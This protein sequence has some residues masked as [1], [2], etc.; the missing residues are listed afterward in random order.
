MHVQPLGAVQLGNGGGSHEN[1]G[2]W[3]PWVKGIGAGQ[4]RLWH[5]P[6]G[7]KGVDGAEASHRTGVEQSTA[8][9]ALSRERPGSLKF[10]EFFRGGL[11]EASAVGRVSTRQALPQW[12][13]IRTREPEDP[14][15]LPEHEQC[16][17][18]AADIG[19]PS[20]L[21]KDS[22]VTVRV[23]NVH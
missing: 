6:L 13:C 1:S 5:E 17:A 2:I 21:P 9:F 22:M 23:H 18:P 3:N 8:D 4:A 12:G 7:A 16:V 14:T 20:G 15:V 19:D 10:M 11:R